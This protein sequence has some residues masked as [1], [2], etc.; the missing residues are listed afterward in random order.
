[1]DNPRKILELHYPLEEVLS[2]ITIDIAN[3]K[4]DILKHDDIPTTNQA[5]ARLK[6]S[7]QSLIDYKSELETKIKE[8]QI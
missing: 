6:K 1:M 8:L 3:T 5:L 4:N 2:F 7:L